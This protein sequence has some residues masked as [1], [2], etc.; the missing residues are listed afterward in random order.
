MSDENKVVDLSKVTQEDLNK[1]R[2][3]NEQRLI[4]I[5][6]HG[7][8]ISDLGNSV[9]SNRLD[10]FLE[11]FLTLEQRVQFEYAFESR[12][13]EMLLSVLSQARQAALTQGVVQ[14]AKNK[15]VIPGRG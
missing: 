15:L 1:I 10:I 11:L 14:S 4:A 12:M 8:N 9:V 7:I 6:Q 13:A 3:A 2:S 5:Q